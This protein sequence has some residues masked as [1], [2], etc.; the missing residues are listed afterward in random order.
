MYFFGAITNSQLAINNGMVTQTMVKQ[1]TEPCPSGTAPAAAEPPSGSL[2]EGSAPP[3][4]RTRH[5]PSAVPDST[6]DVKAISAETFC[7]RHLKP[8]LDDLQ[9][10]IPELGLSPESR[11]TLKQTI[12]ELQAELRCTTID[13]QRVDEGLHRIHDILAT[14]PPDVESSA[15]DPQNSPTWGGAP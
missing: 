4:E 8:M 2:P 12:I 11:Q 9:R 7:R 6:P 10:R 3:H 1:F 13:M 14:E 5:V 15:D